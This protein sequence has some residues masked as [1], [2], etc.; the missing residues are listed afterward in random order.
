MTLAELFAALA[1]WKPTLVGTFPLGLQVEGSDLD[2]ICEA[3]DLD[4]FVLQGQRVRDARVTRLSIDGMP[5]EVFA[6]P[7]PIERQLAFR[8]MVIE[9]RLLT[10]FGTPLRESVL[11]LKR[12]GV[13][14][15]PA[16]AQVLGIPGDPYSQ[17]LTL[18]SL[19]PDQLRLRFALPLG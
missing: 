8:H 11:A 7:V 15:E 14:T 9:G 13:K 10:V 17:L 1:P 4:A 16:F 3:Y 19:S 18:E 12:A 6:Q 2:I 5:V